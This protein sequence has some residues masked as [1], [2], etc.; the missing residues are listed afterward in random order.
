MSQI[1]NLI[2]DKAPT[3]PNDNANED[4]TINITKKVMLLINGIIGAICD[5]DD[6][7]LDLFL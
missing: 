7:E 1:Q 6:N 5:F 2:T 4:L 3:K